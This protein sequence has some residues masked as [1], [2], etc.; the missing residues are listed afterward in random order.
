M[1]LRDREAV[2]SQDRMSMWSHRVSACQRKGASP[3]T[4]LFSHLEVFV[5]SVLSSSRDRILSRAAS[6]AGPPNASNSGTFSGPGIRHFKQEA[7]CFSCE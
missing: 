7:T 4:S 6:M 5:G 1:A 2:A 3:G